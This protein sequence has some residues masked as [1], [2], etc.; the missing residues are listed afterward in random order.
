[1]E[2]KAGDVVVQSGKGDVGVAGARPGRWGH[3]R[4]GATPGACEPM[5][6]AGES[7]VRAMSPYWTAR[8]WKA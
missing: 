5:G 7:A 6:L 8:C 3:C 2:G 1:M 4:A